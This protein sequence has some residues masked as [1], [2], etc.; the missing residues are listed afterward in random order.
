MAAVEEVE[1]PEEGLRPGASRRSLLSVLETAE[2]EV[3]ERGRIPG[4]RFHYPFLSS[5]WDRADALAA[6]A[7]IEPARGLC[8]RCGTPNG[9][10]AG[11]LRWSWSALDDTYGDPDSDDWDMEWGEARRRKKA[12]VNYLTDAGFLSLP[13]S[14]PESAELYWSKP[15]LEG[16]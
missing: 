16:Q 2:Y 4:G 14:D 11:V 10:P 9:S 8:R 12:V 5:L 6:K 3:G 15:E 1:T 13:A 7:T